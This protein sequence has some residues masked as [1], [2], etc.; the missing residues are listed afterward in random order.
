MKS[1]ARVVSLFHI[2]RSHNLIQV[3]ND[4]MGGGNQVKEG[5]GG[6]RASRLCPPKKGEG[7]TS[8]EG[9]AASL[10]SVTKASPKPNPNDA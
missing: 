7:A 8:V 1:D 9:P 2:Y 4:A 3:P 10:S 6:D 5:G